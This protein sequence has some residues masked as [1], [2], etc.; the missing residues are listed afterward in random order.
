MMHYKCI[1][2]ILLCHP[3]TFCLGLKFEL[4]HS[5]QHTYENPI[6]KSVK[7]NSCFSKQCWDAVKFAQ[8]LKLKKGHIQS[9]NCNAI[10]LAR[11][12]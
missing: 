7:S 9:T 2:P 3:N 6:F 12:D 4:K 1:I 11:I 5:L 10:F 8:A